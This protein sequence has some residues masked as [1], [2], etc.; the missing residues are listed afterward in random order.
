[1][2]PS[3]SSW[4]TQYKLMQNET[5]F[6][7]V[8]RHENLVLVDYDHGKRILPGL[9]A[10]RSSTSFTELAHSCL[11]C[12]VKVFPVRL[13]WQETIVLDNEEVYMELTKSLV[14]MV[15]EDSCTNLGGSYIWLPL[16]EIDSVCHPSLAGLA[17]ISNTVN[18]P[19]VPWHQLDWFVTTTMFVEEALKQRVFSVVDRRFSSTSAVMECSAADGKKCFLK[20]VLENS[21]EPLMC[22][23][24]S[25]IAPDFCE[26]PILVVRFP[27][28]QFILTRDHGAGLFASITPEIQLEAASILAKLQIASISHAEKLVK[29]G[30]VDGSP[31]KMK[32]YLDGMYQK[33]TSDAITGS[34]NTELQSV[35]LKLLSSEKRLREKLRIE[36]RELGVFPLVILHN[37]LFT[38]NLYRAE[39]KLKIFD[40]GESIAGHPFMDMTI[41]WMNKEARRAFTDVWK[42]HGFDS[43]SVSTVRVLQRYPTVVRL[44]YTVDS[45]DGYDWEARVL[46]E[47][48]FLL[49][50]L[51]LKDQQHTPVM[52]RQVSCKYCKKT[53]DFFSGT[54][55]KKVAKSAMFKHT[56]KHHNIEVTS[57]DLIDFDVDEHYTA[58]GS[59]KETSHAK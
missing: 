33:L 6:M 48:E 56:A 38:G 32:M 20:A 45:P 41:S 49:D 55:S 19:F 24:A 1:M 28:Q 26:E 31:N 22:K 5:Q 4:E 46:Q 17:E 35:A 3:E 9:F 52:T 11:K 53:Y 7:F 29:A 27:K 25:S 12:D 16:C 21:I 34:A 59:T 30:L 2:K 40:C 51:D 23:E 37:D 10:E 42:A 15:W 36:S 47:F 50:F 13:L 39:S 44:Y 18:C 8:R 57:D 54:K 58:V 14:L 43:P